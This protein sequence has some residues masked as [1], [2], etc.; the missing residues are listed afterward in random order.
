ML[1]QLLSPIHDLKQRSYH[2]ITVPTRMYD[3][4]VGLTMVTS[5]FED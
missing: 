3:F 2:A 1:E 4:S 5:D